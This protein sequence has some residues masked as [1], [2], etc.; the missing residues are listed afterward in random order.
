[1]KATPLCI[2][3]LSVV[4]PSL[5]L[6]AARGWPRT[7]ARR[8]H[9]RMAGF[10]TPRSE[11]TP[12]PQTFTLTGCMDGVGV[13][14]DV[15]N[16]VDMLT[17]G[18]PAA[19]VLQLGDKITEWNG[20]AMFDPATGERRLL[21]EVVTTAES[22]TLVIERAQTAAPMPAAAAPD[23]PKNTMTGED[24]PVLPTWSSG[25]GG[26]KVYKPRGIDTDDDTVEA[27]LIAG[28]LL[29][30]IIFIAAQPA[31]RTWF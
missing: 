23:A 11:L 21:K 26:D 15:D 3:L 7:S 13:G 29:F 24:V 18:K 27:A 22:H 28:A 2:A 16:C 25:Q 17:P 4:E 10:V 30:T 19:A 1:M 6:S 9:P 20:V 12:K 8:T 31:V 14:L 5:T